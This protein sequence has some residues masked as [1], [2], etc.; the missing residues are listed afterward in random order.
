MLETSCE[1]I[2]FRELIGFGNV[3]V[4]DDSVFVIP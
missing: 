1:E 3:W 2:I 4:G